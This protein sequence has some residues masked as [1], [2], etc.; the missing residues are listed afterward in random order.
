MSSYQVLNLSSMKAAVVW[1]SVPCAASS[2]PTNPL[3]NT[4]LLHLFCSSAECQLIHHTIEKIV[5]LYEF[6]FT[7]SV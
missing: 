7:V 6:L 5:V 4:F 2:Q 3:F 1:L